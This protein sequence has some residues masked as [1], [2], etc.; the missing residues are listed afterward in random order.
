MTTNHDEAEADAMYERDE[1]C[2]AAPRYMARLLGDEPPSAQLAMKWQT[3][4][5]YCLVDQVRAVLRQHPESLEAHKL[6]IG[7]MLKFAQHW[8]AEQTATRALELCEQKGVHPDTFRLFRLSGLIKGADLGPRTDWAT[9]KRD[10]KWLWDDAQRHIDPRNSR[11]QLVRLLLGLKEESKEA[12]RTLVD[13][14]DA[15]R[16]DDAAAARV[17]E[18]HAATLRELNRMG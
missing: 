10:F 16:A 11:T 4:A 8:L 14:A 7:V 17:L 9:L 12:S 5:Q 18:A 3:S 15:L 13:L 6:A 1:M 2:D